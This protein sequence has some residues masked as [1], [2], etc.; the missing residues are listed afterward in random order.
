[1]VAAGHTSPA[2]QTA[3]QRIMMILC[4]SLAAGAFA[5]PFL[6]SLSILLLF[7]S[8]HIQLYRTGHGTWSLRLRPE[9][10]KKY[11][12]FLRNP[13]FSILI[14]VF[15]STFASALISDIQGHTWGKVQ[16]RLPYLLL[17]PVFFLMP[18][19][20]DRYWRGFVYGLTVIAT[21][22]ALGVL[23]NYM[24][25][26]E[27]I[28]ASIGRGKSI[29]APSNH[30][31]FSLLTAISVLFGFGAL[32]TG[33]F[34]LRA[35]SG[36]LIAV[37]LVF[38]F[39]FL[40]V[41]SV[42]SGLLALYLGLL[43]LSIVMTV[44]RRQYR[45]TLAT[46]ASLIL[47]PMIAYW[48][49]PSFRTKISYMMHDLGTY[50]QDDVGFYSDGDRIRS[51][52]MGWEVF[53]KNPWWGSDVGDLGYDIALEYRQNFDTDI[54]VKIPH[55]Q[56]VFILASMGLFGAIFIFPALIYP[57]FARGNWKD[58]YIAVHGMVFLTSCIVEP[59]IEGTS[60]ITFHLLFLGL[61]L[62][63]RKTRS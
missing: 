32:L 15:L 17:P 46:L 56:F 9:L 3:D 26:Y 6:I 7:L 30:I 53:K 23:L 49:I 51:I 33:I 43:T 31:R 34:S 38:L 2:V 12:A 55:N 61:L 60:G 39:V 19:M 62:N 22:C 45:W 13:V 47:L 41:Y 37:C 8:A 14:L 35:R 36:R 52:L 18:R 50:T 25:D 28:T 11:I 21:A 24:L 57:Y 48:T 63:R 40:H 44:T 59:T 58:M 1:M 20:E 16:L 54:P 5:S 42:R 4:L 29:P 27:R 10:G